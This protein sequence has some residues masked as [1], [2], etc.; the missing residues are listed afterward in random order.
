VIYD[1]CAGAG[2]GSINLVWMDRVV[3]LHHN[4]LAGRTG[5]F[6]GGIIGIALPSS[7][8]SG[9]LFWVLGQ[10]RPL[11]AFRVRSTKSAIGIS[12]EWHRVVGLALMRASVPGLVNASLASRPERTKPN[13]SRPPVD[14]ATLMASAREALSDGAVCEVR[15]PDGYGNVQVRM[16][17]AGDFR[18]LGNNVVTV[19]NATGGILGVE[20]YDGASTSQRFIEALSG[21]HYGEWGGLAFRLIMWQPVLRRS[22]SSSRAW[23]CGTPRAPQCARRPVNRS[24][25]RVLIPS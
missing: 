22:C 5:R 24:Y 15:L 3:D 7:S 1:A 17:R 16:W 11:T 25:T 23:S 8:V 6:W 4:L 14:L 21:L 20:R 2:L 19:S 9:L 12:R 10:P 13:R 18:S